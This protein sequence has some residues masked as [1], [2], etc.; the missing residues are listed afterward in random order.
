MARS[1]YVIRTYVNIRNYRVSIYRT[2]LYFSTLRERKIVQLFQMP[3]PFARLTI[4]RSTALALSLSSGLLPRNGK[5]YRRNTKRT[6]RYFFQIQSFQPL[7]SSRHGAKIIIYRFPF[8]GFSTLLPLQRTHLFQEDRTN[9]RS[10]II[11][12]LAK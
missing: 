7:S 2:I 4:K 8:K 10:T 5:I 12:Y 1:S 11:H 9:L 3:A 6:N